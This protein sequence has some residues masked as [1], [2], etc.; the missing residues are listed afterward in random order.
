[1]KTNF[2][3]RLLGAT[4]LLSAIAMV[5]PALAQTEAVGEVV[6]TA[7]HRV[8]NV[9]K[10]P[11]AVSVLGADFLAKT[12]TTSVGQIAQ[13]E[14]SVQ[15]SF[16][17]PRNAN[18]NIRGLG[19]NI[20][21]ASD[22][23]EPG[24]GF[25]VD[26]VYYDRPATAT[27]DLVD[28]ASVEVLR[29]P[30]GTLFGK[31]TT[32]G[33]L[34]I[35]TASPTFTPEATGEI[36]GGNYGYVQ[37]KAS[38]S[39]ALID[40]K[41]AG[42]LSLST[43]SHEGYVTNAGDNGNRVN[44]VQNFNARAQ[45]LYTPS[46]DF[47]LRVI[48][49]YSKQNSNCCDLVLAGVVTPSNGKNF[50]AL[51]KPFGYTPVVDPFNRQA[52]TNSNIQAQQET[53]GFSAQ[54]DWSLQ[55]V[56]LTS[57]TAYRFWN[58]WPANDV[59][60]TPLSVVTQSQTGDYQRQFSQEFRIASSGVNR[61]DYTG[62]L[63]FFKEQIS[64]LSVMQY[65]NAGSAFLLSPA[66]PAAVADGYTLNSRGSFDTNSFAAFG[67]TVWHVL[68]RLN[69]TTGLRYTYDEKYGSFTQT[70]SGGG[71]LAGLPA[72]FTNLRPLL[73][74]ADQFSVKS[75]QGDLSG[76][77]NLSYQAADNALVYINYARG[78]KSG[79]LNLVQL[80]AGAN[81]VVAPESVDSVE[82]GAK[83]QFF[84][85]RL[86]VNGDIFW[87]RDRDYQA[88]IY[89]STL[90]KQYLSNV[91]EVRSE[92]AEVDIS[93]Q[94]TR[95]LSLYASGTFDDA[96][97]ASYVDGVCGLENITQGH[98]DLSGRPLAGTPKW[99]AAA[100]GEYSVPVDLRAVEAAAYLGVDYSYRSSIYSSGTDSIYSQIPALSLVNARLGLRASTGR[101]DAYLW[102]RNLFD[103]RYFTFVAAGVGNTGQ[104]IAQLGDPRTFG[105]TL[106]VHY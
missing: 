47:K 1:M 51:S 92:G 12:N 82:A 49:D 96:I 73:G 33:A 74:S 15:F 77:V 68:P 106:H 105:V 100:G 14:P 13:L 48:A 94:P 76:Q 29:G 37:A 8:E 44:S 17:N 79:G 57:I 39:G 93:A 71:S 64:A 52:D 95:H 104:L 26:G 81:P 19:N 5:T 35:T 6:V 63:Y 36:S 38:V 23:I 55:N 25:Y 58:W 53:G 16:F 86:T 62:G 91:P 46:A 85:R 20:G 103:D 70:A 101:W 43:T 65:G 78:Y 42:R 66:V 97:Y 24:V 18:I 54:A 50:V 30:Q 59:D 27:F 99:A 67:Q 21:L 61:V 4:A 28:L 34:N 88:N 98:C 9:Q 60:Y 89:D 32:A 3:R 22:G 11:V 87:E 102:A 90:A 40:D 10:V 84:D 41:L 69:L 75:N 80:P 83:T 56:V 72:V 31:N 2:R 7:R 45:L